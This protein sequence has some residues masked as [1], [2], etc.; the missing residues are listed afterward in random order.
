MTEYRSP[1]RRKTRQKSGFQVNGE[2]TGGEGKFLKSPEYYSESSEEKIILNN[3]EVKIREIFEDEKGIISAGMYIRPKEEM[4]VSIKLIFENE[5]VKYSS[6]K[7][8]EIDP[9][10]WSAIGEYC[11]IPLDPQVDLSGDLRAEITLNT[12]SN[13]RANFF[14]LNLKTITWEDYITNITYEDESSIQD[15]F[16]QRTS[17]TVPYLFYLNHEQPIHPDIGVKNIKKGDNSKIVFL[18]SCNRCGRYLPTEFDKENQRNLISFGNHCVGRSPCDH[19]GFGEIRLQETEI[20]P[21][22]FPEKV[23]QITHEEDGDIIVDLYYGYQLECKACKKFYVNA[24]LNPMRNSTQHR[25]DSLRR[26][27][28]EVLV[29]KLLDKEW[30]YHRFRKE[31]NKEFDKFIWNKFDRECF[32]CGKELEEC[33][34]MDLDHTMPLAALWSLSEGATCLCSDCNSQ[35][36]DK[37]PVDFYTNQ[38]LIE[39]SDITGIDMD[40][41][42]SREVNPDAIKK[43]KKDIKWFF[44]EFLAK[45]DYQKTRG[46]KKTADLILESIQ[47]RINKSDRDISLVKEY[48]GETGHTPETVTLER[49][50]PQN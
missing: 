45:D 38:E 22:N 33:S 26:R 10:Q 12:D 34:D 28:I 42:E 7:K 41:L 37:F 18:K 11:E 16:N 39:L 47:K 3:N 36:S 32:K 49:E 17:L 13:I 27:A 29:R 40:T 30:I 6:T 35:K 46:G 2:T 1:E 44:D 14:G 5:D 23:D 21:E 9:D 19:S 24:A 48:V 8:E 15:K 4:S 20:R 50:S 31:K 25:E 43:L